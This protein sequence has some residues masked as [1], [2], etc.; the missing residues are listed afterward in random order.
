[1]LLGCPIFR[2][3]SILQRLQKLICDQESFVGF[4]L[5]YI[6]KIHVVHNVVRGI[7]G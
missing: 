5:L 6:K 3:F 4:G 7:G 1:M 2:H